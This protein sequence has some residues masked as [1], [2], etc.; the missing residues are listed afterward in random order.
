[1]RELVLTAPA[2]RLHGEILA[3]LMR[4]GAS[5]RTQLADAAGVDVSTIVRALP[6]LVAAGWISETV[7]QMQARTRG[8][9]IKR[10]AVRGGHHLAIG[11]KIGPERIVG[12]VTD[13]AGDVIAAGTSPL[14][15]RDP[16]RVLAA[17][18]EMVRVLA[19]RGLAVVDQPEA[20]VVGLGVGVGGH[21]SKGRVVTSPILGWQGV[22]VSTVLAAATRLPTVV[23]NDVNALAA[24]EHL[25]GYG[26]RVDDLAVLTIGR[27]LGCGLVLHGR[28]LVG[29]DGAAGEFGHLPL[30]PDGPPCGCGGRGCLETVASDRA[31]VAAVRARTGD[32]DVCELGD[33]ERLAAAGDQVALECLATTGELLGRGIAALVNLVNPALVI[34]AGEMVSV[35]DHLEAPMRRAAA[36]HA[37]S[38]AWSNCRLKIDRGGDEM[39]ARGAAWLA[40]RAAVMRPETFARVSPEVAV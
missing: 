5:S 40:I 26:R 39:W 10:V 36:E 27:G 35:I 33:V 14:D 18:S 20:R 32:A 31:L 16:D 17:V 8:R 12:A 1:M 38:S 13:L 21:V 11:V 28:L 7:D 25:L 24:G 30:I 37:F 6:E 3:R 19:G 4:A 15:T 22:E 23:A 34:V 29:A 2:Q 9:P